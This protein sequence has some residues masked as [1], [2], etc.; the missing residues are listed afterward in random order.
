MRTRN[1]GFALFV[2]VSCLVF[3]GPLRSLARLSWENDSYSHVIL[4]PIISSLL[5]YLERKRVFAAVHHCTGGGTLLFGAGIVSFYLG[6]DR[7]FSLDR[8]DSLA[9]L[10]LSLV[11]VWIAGFNLFYGI[12]A[13]RS[14][15][16]PLLF[17]FLTIPVPSFLLARIVLALQQGSAEMLGVLFRI[18]GV[19]FF[20]SGFV[21]SLPGVNIEIA[22]QCSGIRSSI[23]LLITVLLAGHF[24]L[25]AAWRKMSLIVFII[26]IVVLKNA[27]R[28]ATISWLSV[29]VNRG[30][31][32]G[33]LHHYGGIPFSVLSVAILAPILYWLQ[34]SEKCA[35]RQKRGGEAVLPEHSTAR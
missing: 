19:P 8:A 5:I 26:P 12:Q 9:L 33:R 14:A 28:I 2:G 11:F 6:R 23:A 3:W 7:F 30:F 32:T 22:R 24:F 35:P 1:I 31:L 17:L 29:Y 15:V 16:F 4:I 27:L 13:S 34:R 21:F 18:A 10:T 20:R 25:R